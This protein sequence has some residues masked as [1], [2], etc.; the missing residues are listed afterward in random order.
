MDWSKY[1]VHLV[2]PSDIQTIQIGDWVAR[3][4]DFDPDGDGGFSGGVRLSTTGAEPATHLG[5]STAVPVEAADLARLLRAIR[6][7][8]SCA[9]IDNV[10]ESDR[11]RI[12]G[13]VHDA[14]TEHGIS[15]AIMCAAIQSQLGYVIRLSDH[16]LYETS[17]G[18]A[19]VSIGQPWYW[20]DTLT[21]LGLQR[22]AAE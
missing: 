1:R 12:W 9:V 10:L 19:A 17:S 4:I 11:P 16:T 13:W 18:S 15:G 5:M 7:G 22:I 20:G 6:N 8:Q 21:D 3:K 14:M 2:L